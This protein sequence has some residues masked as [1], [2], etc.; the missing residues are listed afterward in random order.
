MR[1]SLDGIHS[2]LIKIADEKISEIKDISIE[3]T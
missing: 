1:N 2:W 3:T